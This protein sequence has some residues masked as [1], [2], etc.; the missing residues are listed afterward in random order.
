MRKLFVFIGIF[1]SLSQFSYS[2]VNLLTPPNNFRCQDYV[3]E[4]TWEP[5]PGGVRSY[6]LR[7]ST[8]PDLS[9]PVLDTSMLTTTSVVVTLPGADVQ[10][11][12]RVLAIVNPNPLQLDSSDIWTFTTMPFPPSTIEPESNSLCNNL[13]TYFRWSPVNNAQNYRVQISNT[14]WFLTILK[15]TIVSSTSAYIKLPNWDTKYF[16][17]VLATTNYGCATYFSIVDS[18][19][20]NRTPPSLLQPDDSLSSVW[21]PVTFAWNVPTNANSY[22]LQISTQPDFGVILYD[23]ITSN[24][25]VTKFITDYN[26]RFYWRV[27]A[28]YSDCETEFSN[29]RTFRTAYAPPQNLYPPKDTF[30]HSNTVTFKWDAVNGA[31]SYRLQ[32]TEGDSLNLNAIVLDTLINARQFTYYFGKSL[33]SYC[34]RVRAE[35]NQNIGLWNADTMRFKTT[36]S[37]PK[38][39]SPQD[40]EETGIT[41]KFAWSQDIPG[42]TFEL[43][44]S[45]TNN[46]NLIQHR[47]YDYSGLTK[48]TIVLKL[49]RFNKKYWW[50]VRVSD[51]YCRSDWSSPTYFRTKLLKPILTFPPNNSVKMPLQITFEWT[52][53][54]GWESFEIHIS[55]D[56][57][58]NT[59]YA[60]RT[61]IIT[62]SVTISDFEQSTKYYWRV[63][64]VNKEDTSHW[65]DV[66]SFTT[67]PNPLEI[68][69]L[70]S[71]T[72]N[73]ENFP[74]AV[75]FIWSSVPKAKY[76][77]LQV[78][79][80]LQFSKKLYDVV[81]ISDTF[82]LISDLKP[83]SEYFWRVL[84]YNDS[85]SSNW[86]SIWRFRTQPPLPQ[87]PVYLSIPPNGSMGVNTALSLIWS[88]VQYA[89]LYHL[90]VATDENFLA[91]T[92]VV[93][94]SNLI[95]PQ[96]YL[97]GLEF[98]KKYFW[99]V[100]AYNPAGS[101]PWSETWWF[102]TMVS[103]VEDGQGLFVISYNPYE[104]QLE[105]KLLDDNFTVN[106]VVLSDLLGRS[107]FAT[108]VAANQQIVLIPTNELSRGI[109]F[110]NIVSKNKT[111]VCKIIF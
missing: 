17:R 81:N 65:S 73:G 77:Q 62:N 55:K 45:D 83:M 109:Y 28:V 86:S 103:S 1:F 32:V 22:N 8:Y 84:A 26:T 9:N 5:Y 88:P 59:I 91:Q 36:F 35:D 25:V 33:Q 23:D 13:T 76:Y 20:T 70:I 48:D 93:D 53:P 10:Y 99:H 47:I 108:S 38:H 79:E 101:T 90:Q 7:V 56:A 46:F 98:D 18:F 14:E 27:K 61:G 51:A 107:L 87:G 2:V 40:G 94:D 75:T 64:A 3:V 58:F 78:A 29:V 80:D 21:G 106:K 71:P 24:K 4:F 54:E 43:Q 42:S 19:R 89:E 39:L 97:T 102:K 92:L 30:C 66:F 11:Y 69:K 31:S 96:K 6:A 41:V 72:N 15:D 100:R 82:Y 67:G 44:V 68:P 110:V 95:Q 111:F 52:K 37:P 16:W 34:W 60:G 85:S 12:W 63:R 50:R 105:L 57:Q 49:P 74:L 104:K